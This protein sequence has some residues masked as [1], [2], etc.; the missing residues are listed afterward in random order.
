MKELLL[1]SASI[2]EDVF[3]FRDRREDFAIVVAGKRAFKLFEDF[4]CYERY[5]NAYRQRKRGRIRHMIPFAWVG[6]KS[7]TF[8]G[9]CILADFEAR[10]HNFIYVDGVLRVEFYF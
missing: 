6:L 3:S 4:P 9:A 5:H 1:E 10:Q 8:W 2:I 7:P